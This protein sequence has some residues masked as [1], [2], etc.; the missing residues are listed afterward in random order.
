MA[1]E[2]RTAPPD[3]TSRVLGGALIEPVGARSDNGIRT[4][5]ARIRRM[6]ER[7]PDVQDV[8]FL[9]TL[10]FS[11]G[12]AGLLLTGLWCAAVYRIGDRANGVLHLLATCVDVLALVFGLLVLAAGS[13]RAWVGAKRGVFA[14]LP[15]VMLVFSGFIVSVAALIFQPAP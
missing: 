3:Q 6:T 7:R 1:A 2:G 5:P 14:L 8:S 9:A 12:V 15:T 10:A 11:L 13:S 4:G